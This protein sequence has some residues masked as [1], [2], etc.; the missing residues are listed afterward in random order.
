MRRWSVKLAM[1]LL[2]GAIINVAVACGCAISHNRARGRNDLPTIERQYLWERYAPSS[3]PKFDI[4]SR[5]S[6]SR[7]F[8]STWRMVAIGP[9]PSGF[10]VGRSEFGWPCRALFGVI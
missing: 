3:Y 2:A 5:G 7:R 4:E 10:L 8:G 9:P 1:F 6:A